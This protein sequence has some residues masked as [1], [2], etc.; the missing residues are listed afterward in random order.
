M[1]KRQLVSGEGCATLSVSSLFGAKVASD[2]ACLP[3]F[4][5][6]AS[7]V[8]CAD[9]RA[10]PFFSSLHGDGGGKMGSCAA[11]CGKR[12]AGCAGCDRMAFAPRRQGDG[13]RSL[14]IFETSPRLAGPALFAQKC[15][16]KFCRCQP[17]TSAGVFSAD[18]RADGAG[19]LD[20]RS[21][22]GGDEPPR[23][24]KA[25]GARRLA[26]VIHVKSCS[27]AVFEALP[28]GSIG[29]A[30]LTIALVTLA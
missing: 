13:A 5:A 6:L 21:G 23:D 12:G 19:R 25:G 10:A 16:S 9:R 24:G 20:T 15:R 2:V 14:I 4:F 17:R 7:H 28:S 27:S 30:C 18:R 8:L 11:F 1:Q 22:F 26:W 3:I 29:L